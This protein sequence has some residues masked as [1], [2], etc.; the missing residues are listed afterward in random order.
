MIHS[1][2]IVDSNWI[3][4]DVSTWA[5]TSGLTTPSYAQPLTATPWSA[6]TPGSSPFTFNSIAYDVRSFSCKVD[7]NPDRVQVVGQTG[8]TWIQPTIREI[9]IDVEVVHNGTG[10]IADTKT[11]T[12]RSATMN[13]NSTTNQL[14]FTDMYLEKY[15]EDVSADDTSIKTVSYSGYAAAVVCR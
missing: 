1:R 14:T 12:A 3:A 13:L 9:T 5:T 10:L 15:D 8:T 7:Q 11:M 4:N 2:M 6:L